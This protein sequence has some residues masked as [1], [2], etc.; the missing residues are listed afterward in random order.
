MMAEKARRFIEHRAEELIMSSPDPSTQ[1]HIGRG[2]RNFDSAVW[3]REKQNAAI[4][5]TYAKFTKN[6]ATK[7]RPFSAGNKRLADA[8][9]LDPCGALV[10]GWLIP[11][12]T[13]HGSG[14]GKICSVK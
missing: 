13:T 14:E 9:H 1:N 2:V 4:S 11:G 7:N 6:P 8:S 5:G 3:D 10:S 12:P